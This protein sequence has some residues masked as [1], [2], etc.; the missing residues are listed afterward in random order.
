MVRQS[1][2]DIVKRKYDESHL[3]R[4]N[5]LQQDRIAQER[6]KLSLE[7]ESLMRQGQREQLKYDV[8]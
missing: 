7:Q 8:S 3:N 5:E 1:H 2:F 6:A 4:L